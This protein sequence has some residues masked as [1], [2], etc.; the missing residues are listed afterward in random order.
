MNY[1]Y[2]GPA[3]FREED[4]LLFN[5]R[6][7]ETRSLYDLLMS[8]SL[9]VLF[10]RS[11]M[12]KTSL[13]Q[14]GI[15][16]LLRFSEYDPI[17]LRLNRTDIPLE[18]QV[19]SDILPGMPEG[20]TLWETLRTYNQQ[21]H[22][23][24]FLIF[25][26]FEEI[27]TLYNE[28]QR[29]V[30]VRHLADVI[31]GILP[32]ELQDILKQDIK[33]GLS[34][35]EALER[36][37]P[38]RVKIV[39]SIR[40]DMLHFLHALSGD[41]RTILRNRFELRGLQ[42]MRAKE[43]IVNPAARS[44]EEGNFKSPPYHFSED[45]VHEILSYLS[46]RRQNQFTGLMQEP[47]IESFQLQLV[48]KSIEEKVIAEA[49]KGQVLITPGFYQGEQGLSEVLN[50]FYEDTLRKITDEVQRD[51]ARRL[52]EGHLVKNERR[53][54][55]DQDT[56]Q[57]THQVAPE[58]LSLLVNERL[59]RRDIRETGVYYELSHDT[60]VHPALQSLRKW[61]EQE[62]RRRAA[63]AEA[64]FKVEEEKRQEAERLKQEAVSQR[65]LAEEQ[66]QEAE[67]QKREAEDQKTLAEKRR[68]RSLYI[69]AIAVLLAVVSV[70]LAFVSEKRLEE[71]EHANAGRDLLEFHQYIDRGDELFKGGYFDSALEMYQIADSLRIAH[72]DFEELEQA[73]PGLKEK[74]RDCGAALKNK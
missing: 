40:S 8:Q 30:F 50:Q 62:V 68:K 18:R 72:P 10:S 67:R 61:E 3:S 23:A 52:I 47:E 13:L 55:V 21:R 33:N 22:G 2:P 46:R 54:S 32:T 34:D 31:N 43:A 29:A 14:A 60:L 58:T 56:I 36:E 17:M 53:V 4:E 74:I 69:T 35:A 26:Q 49:N 57:I 1:R 73:G 24:P 63:E 27:F 65:A 6:K 51:K 7:T 11:G 28:S 25:D 44:Q 38:P 70:W 48:C 16:P 15:L 71:I 20:S 39:F 19:S 9:V 5:G 59:L 66:K 37:K 41:I 45:A 42:P 12:G 64:K